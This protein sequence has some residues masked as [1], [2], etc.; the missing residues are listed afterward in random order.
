MEKYINCPDS[1][2]IASILDGGKLPCNEVVTHYYK[3]T[4][5]Y[6]KVEGYNPDNLTDNLTVTLTTAPLE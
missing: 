1:Y 5:Y 6:P 2:P 4:I 3:L